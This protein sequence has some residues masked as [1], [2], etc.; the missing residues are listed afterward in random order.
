MYIVYTLYIM[1]IFLKIHLCGERWGQR[2]AGEGQMLFQ[3][4][5]PS[6]TFWAPEC[7]TDA[8]PSFSPQIFE[9]QA[10][11]NTDLENAFKAYEQ[12][13]P[14]M[15]LFQRDND[16]EM[17]AISTK[18]SFILGLC[19]IQK[20]NHWNMEN[21]LLTALTTRCPEPYSAYLQWRG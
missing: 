9:L 20:I 2:D 19:L 3:L 8:G 11:K 6:S 5:S 14:R 18:P 7:S 4:W 10:I 17:I 13:I 1:A 21:I 12:D 16:D 15:R